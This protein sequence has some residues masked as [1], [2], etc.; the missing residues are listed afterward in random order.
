MAW[1]GLQTVLD[2]WTAGARSSLP[3]YGAALA[4]YRGGRPHFVGASGLTPAA[5]FPAYSVTKTFTAVALLRLQER[6]VLALDQTLDHWLPA[7]P[8]AGDVSLRQLLRHSAGVP[9]YS[10]MPGHQ[11]ALRVSPRR[12]WTFD[13]FILHACLGRLDFPP[14]TSWAYSNTGYML[15]KR[16]L[17]SSLEAGFGQVL[18]QHA[19]DPLALELTRELRSPECYESLTPGFGRLGESHELVDV[20]GGYDPGWCA[21]GV[22]AS[23]TT[24]LCRFMVGAFDGTLLSEAS[25][26]EMC[27]W[28]P[29]LG[30]EGP[31]NPR[32]GLGLMARDTPF[33]LELGHGGSGPGYDIHL[34]HFPELE[35][36]RGQSL[37][38]A[39]MCNSDRP[40]DASWKLINAVRPVVFEALADFKK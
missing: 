14:D 20:R 35:Q 40:A 25:R 37:T 15:L 29:A 11:R 23:T 34:S 16:V 5:I 36:T 27:E 39:A 32:Y 28:V 1:P 2:E 7:L 31:G 6:G 19:V 18:R 21:T 38:V 33:G 22:V 10:A 12:A 17:E 9:N 8:W 30:V 3:T 4:V 26:R 13:E 24:E